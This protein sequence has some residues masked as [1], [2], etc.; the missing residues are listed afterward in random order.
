MRQMKKQTFSWLLIL[1]M[2]FSLISPGSVWKVNAEETYDG[3][4]YVTVER[5]TLGQGFAQEPVKIGF[6]QEETLADIILRGLGDKVVSSTGD[7]GMIF[8]G[9]K[10]GGAPAGWTPEQIPEKIQEALKNATS[11]DGTPTPVTLEDIAAT[12]RSA[13]DTLSNNDYTGQSYFMLCVDNASASVGFSGVKFG[14]GSGET[15]TY[16]D[17][18][19]VRIQYGIYNYGGDLNTA[20]GTP[21]IDFP[22]K[23]ALI[24]EVADYNG[25]KNSDIYQS[26]IAVLEDWDATGEEVD[27]VLLPLLKNSRISK[28]HDQAVRGIKNRLAEP[29][30]GN[31]WQVLSIARSG[32]EGVS[33]YP[34]YYASVEA[35]VKEK[36]SNILDEKNSTENSRLIIGLTAIGANPENVAGYN[37]VTP[38]TDLNFVKKQGLNGSVYALIALDCGNYTTL[39]AEKI[40][41]TKEALIQE[42]VNSALETGGWTFSGDK[43]DPDMTGMAIQA[44]APYYSENNDVKTAVDTALDAL[45][46]LQ[47]ENGCFASLGTANSM[48]C[49]Q[50][51]CALSALKLDAET[52]ERFIKNGNS[53]LDAMLSFYDEKTA[54]FKYSMEDASMV[55]YA[56]AQAAYALTAYERFKKNQNSLYDMSDAQKLYLCTHP[57]IKLEDAKEATCTAEGYTG[58]KVCTVCGKMQEKGKTVAKKEHTVVVDAAVAPTAATPGKTEGKHCSVCNTVIKAQETIPA[59]G[60]V[61]EPATETPVVKAPGKT[62]VNKVQSPAKKR[63]KLTWKKKSGITGYQIQVS[64]SS[65][66]KKSKTKLYKI[67]RAKTTSKVIKSLKSGKKYYV[68]IRTYK[69]VTVNGKKTTAYSKWSAKKSVKVK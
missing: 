30:Y 11:W 61:N 20:Y 35:A 65:R 14:D 21:L 17:G 48:S 9:Y 52:E 46:A 51:L 38:L 18:S 6:H 28:I 2:V 50:V 5:F 24:K 4:V 34:K 27:S 26:A 39:S 7:Y 31:E 36:K 37:L 66:F 59:N 12:G 47:D 53:V 43:A 23:D 8:N 16:Q 62:S 19:V 40:A 44:L 45:S 57:E 41:A 10:D 15:T 3:Y 49:A 1:V 60:G 42:I 68:R 67:G 25:D 13:A 29:G 58:D 56:T 54:G 69:T 55:D 64:T 32:I 33:W 22:D 63:I